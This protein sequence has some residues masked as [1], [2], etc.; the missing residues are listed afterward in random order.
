MIIRAKPS[1]KPSPHALLAEAE[2]LRLRF[3]GG[4]ARRK[5]ELIAALDRAD[6]RLP[7]DLLRFH[8]LLC[9]WRAYPDD[10]DV[11]GRVERSLG[12]FARRSDLTRLASRLVDSGIAGTEIR[13]RFFAATA[14]W[15]VER[16][17][18]QVRVDWKA[19]DSDAL[20]P[21]LP[22]LVHPAETPALDE[23]DLP[24]R[25]WLAWLGGPRETD[26][27]FLVRRLA[28]MPM[29]E[30]A[31]ETLYDQLDPPL[32][33][34]PGATTP[35]RTR[36]KRSG[37]RLHF[38]RRAL[39]RGRPSI[40]AVASLRARAVR[41]VGAREGER[42][43]DLAR[44]SM[45]TRSRDL[46]AF[47]NGDPR[48]VRVVDFG[49]GL[50]FA[51]IG[52]RPERRLLLEAVYGYLTVKNGVPIGY[53]LTAS[54]FGSAELAYNVFETW[55]GAEAGP[56][57]ARVLAMTRGLFGCDAFTIV[58]YQLGEGNDEALG[59]GAWWF[60][61]KM[62]FRPRDRAAT[63]LMRAELARM[64][65]RPGHRSRLATLRRL[66]RAPVHLFLARSR[67]DVLGEVP[68][69]N[70]GLHVSR[71]LAER[72]GADREAATESS[73]RAARET[74]GGGPTSAWSAGE[75]MAWTIW[76]PLVTILPGIERWNASERDALVDVIRAKGG[77]RESAFVRHFDA[78]PRLRAAI[79]RLAAAPPRTPRAG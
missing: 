11:L 27:A 34:L 60:Y 70:V 40:E 37:A 78:H 54:L 5:Q 57:Y 14:R 31:R 65:S 59:S 12:R 52:V 18:S 20:E 13:F 3:G 44:A 1:P 16:W 10:R 68:L 9:F 45:V 42:W 38:Q 7:A 29:D 55:R 28:R 61:Q 77:R 36:A 48:D 72:F 19:F 8:E 4:A 25:E 79:R 49:N 47:A 62:G 74:L 66:A 30:V 35:S 75:R 21:W 23:Y 71:A 24:V 33:L 63:R 73:A 76:A 22:L 32:V 17:P 6:L 2:G 56:I 26:A 69:A 67:G 15:L 50:A 46:D 53:V 41:E 51:C 43:I 39:E 64:R 58:P